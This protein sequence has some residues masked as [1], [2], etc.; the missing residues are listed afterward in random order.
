[1]ALCLSPLAYKA[2]AVEVPTYSECVNMGVEYFKAVGSW[3]RLSDGRDAYEVAQ[4]RCSRSLL[5][6]G[7]KE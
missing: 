2:Q 1:M 6:F 7:T 4:E 3:P 5:A